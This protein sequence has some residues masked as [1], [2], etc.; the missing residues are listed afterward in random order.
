MTNRIGNNWDIIKHPCQDA[1]M[2]QNGQHI[3]S[4]DAFSNYVG[5]ADISQ[6]FHTQGCMIPYVGTLPNYPCADSYPGFS[7]ELNLDIGKCIFSYDRL[8]N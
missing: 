5:A 7:D 1:N 6:T 2:K 8:K 3:Y 4:T